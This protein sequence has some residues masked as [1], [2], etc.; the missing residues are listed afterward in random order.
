MRLGEIIGSVVTFFAGEKAADIL[1]NVAKRFVYASIAIAGVVAFVVLIESLMTAAIVAVPG[2]I[3]AFATAVL[4]RNLAECVGIIITA[5][6][7]RALL[8]FKAKL[9]DKL[10][11]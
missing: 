9:A 11:S 6:V 7:A 2:D 8:R 5:T 3:G 1:G 10:T 4:P